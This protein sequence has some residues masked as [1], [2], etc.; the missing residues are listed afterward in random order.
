MI[1]LYLILP[2]VW[3]V[4]CHTDGA[5]QMH[6][7]RA[8][9][10]VPERDHRPLSPQSVSGAEGVFWAP[11]RVIMSNLPKEETSIEMLSYKA[12]S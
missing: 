6:F 7:L 5:E 9:L 1:S 2:H 3:H 10:R 11:Q 12:N 4:P 8:L